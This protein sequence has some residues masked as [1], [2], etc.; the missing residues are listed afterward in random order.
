M[1]M[2]RGIMTVGNDVYVGG[3][4]N[5]KEVIL[6]QGVYKCYIKTSNDAISALSLVREGSQYTDSLNSVIHIKDDYVGFFLK[7]PNLKNIES[8]KELCDEDLFIITNK[9]FM[10]K[11]KG[12]KVLK[13]IKGGYSIELC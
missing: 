10:A 4:E 1:V 8:L 2:F 3:L 6:K 12:D 13:R 7:D 11:I 5:A 9:Y